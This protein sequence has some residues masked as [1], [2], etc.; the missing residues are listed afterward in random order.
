IK[1]E[2]VF[3][4]TCKQDPILGI[5]W[6]CLDF[7]DTSVNLCSSCYM[8]DK[9]NTDH[10]FCRYNSADDKG[11]RMERRI[12]TVAIHARGIF[13]GARVVRGHNWEW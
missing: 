13:P 9:H 3:C 6:N 10:A 12:N 5:R 1:H 4:H 2:S 8:A 11:I 7:K